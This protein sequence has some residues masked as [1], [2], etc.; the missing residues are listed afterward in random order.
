MARHVQYLLKSILCNSH[1]QIQQLTTSGSSNPFPFILEPLPRVSSWLSNHQGGHQ[2][3]WTPVDQ[4][5]TRHEDHPRSLS[6]ASQIWSP[7]G[8]MPVS[9]KRFQDQATSLCIL[10]LSF[11]SDWFEMSPPGEL[12][13]Q[14]F[15]ELLETISGKWWLSLSDASRISSC[16]EGFVL[17]EETYLPLIV[18]TTMSFDTPLNGIQSSTLDSFSA[19]SILICSKDSVNV[20]SSVSI[21]FAGMGVNVLLSNFFYLLCDLFWPMHNLCLWPQLLLNT[22]HLFSAPFSKSEFDEFSFGFSLGGKQPHPKFFNFF[23]LL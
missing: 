3:H 18:S 17:T 5:D 14:E 11:I 21:S 15:G 12:M 9:P 16:N 4:W 2:G 20:S 10:L 1:E 22:E 23:F 13:S 7:A 8:G 19:T 6:R